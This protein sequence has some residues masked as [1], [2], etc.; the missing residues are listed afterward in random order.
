MP[1][2]KV[3]VVGAGA[4]GSLFGGYLS[5]AGQEVWLVDPWV[6]HVRAIAER[7]LQ[8]VEPGGETRLVRP[9]AVSRPEGVGPCDLILVFV[10]SYH[11]EQAAAGLGCLMGE[12]TVVLTLQ[13]GL[14]NVDV[15]ARRVP[16]TALLAGVTGQGANVLGPGRIHHA[17]T[18]DTVI[19]ELDGSVTERLRRLVGVFNEAGLPASSSS[20]IQGIIWGKLLVNVAINP[21]TAILKVRNGQLLEIP[22][23]ADIMKDAVAEAIAV[24]TGAGVRLPFSDPWAHVE[25]VT[26]RTGANRSSMLQDVEAGRP[27]E[28]DVI[29]GA[30]ARE[31]ARLG[32]PAPVNLTLTRLVKCLEE[33]NRTGALAAGRG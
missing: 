29:S 12:D 5:A 15:L 11:T 14:G 25:E 20:N 17:G 27:T 23:A 3:A 13:N 6:E 26:R 7:G 2:L 9:R 22:G 8:I 30:V 4:M 10:K 31:G 32:I 33:L 24:A 18:G 21:L 16:R 19:G 28:I 1:T